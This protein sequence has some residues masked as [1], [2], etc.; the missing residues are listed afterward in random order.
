ML[1][2]VLFHSKGY[3]EKGILQNLKQIIYDP[4]AAALWIDKIC[5]EKEQEQGGRK[6]NKNGNNDPEP[7]CVIDVD[8]L[9]IGDLAVEE[10]DTVNDHQDGLHGGGKRVKSLGI[11]LVEG[12]EDNAVKKQCPDEG[13]IL[14]L[15]VFK[16]EKEEER[17]KAIFDDGITGPKVEHVSLVNLRDDYCCQFSYD[18][19]NTR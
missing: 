13:D 19:K 3:A 10:D 6:I 18:R 5:R 11:F 1:G 9:R 4:I 17:E 15:F 2:I 8:D 7:L 12:D 14:C 16:S